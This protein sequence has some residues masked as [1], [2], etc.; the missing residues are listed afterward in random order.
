MTSAAHAPSASKATHA[1][2]PAPEHAAEWATPAPA[3]LVALAIACFCFFAI[4]TGLVEHSAT[5]Y[6]ACWLFGGFVVQF[7]VAM[8]ELREGNT[9][10]GNVFLFFSAFFMLAGSM[11]YIVGAYFGSPGGHHIDHHIDGWAWLVLSVSL[12]LWTPAY[13]KRSPLMLALIVIAIDVGAF[14]VALRDLGVLSSKVANV[15]AGWA[16]LAA[17]IFG[18]YVASAVILNTAFGKSVLPMPGPVLK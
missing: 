16:L 2:E 4:L 15:P 9:T 11:K 3:G 7:T 18:I 6:L 13:L 14:L 8:I 1:A 5:P 10:G 17:G 12:I